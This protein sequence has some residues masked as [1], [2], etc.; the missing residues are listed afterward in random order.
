MQTLEASRARRELVQRGDR[1]AGNHGVRP[2]GQAPW[3]WLLICSVGFIALCWLLRDFVTDDAWITARYADNL[4][5]GQGFVWN[6]SGPRV[7]GF[8]NPLLVA[9]EALAHLLGVASVDAARAIGVGS[10]VALLLVIAR[11]AP[12]VVGDIAT[13]VAIALTALCPS[14]ALWA[15]GGLETLPAALVITAGVLLI[16]WR[17]ASRGDALGAG[18]VLALLPW[19]RPEGLAVAIAVAVFAEGPGLRHRAGRR[20]R[21]ARLGCTLGLPVASQVVLEGLRLVV[22]GH[23][24]PNSVLYKSGS[25]GAIDVLA[26]FAA[27][28]APIL[29]VAAIGLHVARGRQ[30]LLVIPP[31]LYALGSIGTLDSANAFSRFFLPTWP[32]CALLAGLAVAAFHVRFEKNRQQLT[33]AATALLISAMVLLPPGGA[34]WAKAFAGDY[35]SCRQQARAQTAMWLD[36]NTPRDTR[37]SISDAGLVPARSGGR[38]AI[39]QF[40][41]NEPAIQKS[42]RLGV[43]PRVAMTFA[44]RPD[45]LILASTS[46]VEFRGLYS[47]DR[48][49]TR[50]AR[51]AHFA[52][53]HV[54]HGLGA[55]CDYHLFIYRRT[56]P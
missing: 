42:G 20:E 23:L 34:P 27:Q 17:E 32:M 25:G 21:I 38:T 15:V 1:G 26:K 56:G 22:F 53:A 4:A 45:V 41:L 11:W 6:P 48:Q 29:V 31:A 13:K 39:D 51:F 55:R 54:A 36:R 3:L 12:A 50:E 40:L 37:F 35:A 28:E 8:S 9:A 10:G 16:C 19:L 5:S 43:L 46:A 2:R 44:R 47:T 49:M 24:L 7:E 14:L 18:A 33:L 52:L 30:R